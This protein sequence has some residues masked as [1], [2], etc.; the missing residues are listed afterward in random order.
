M[1]RTRSA[2]DAF[3]AGQRDQQAFA[4]VAVDL[5]QAGI[6]QHLVQLGAALDRGDL[7]EQLLR[8]VRRLDAA[9]HQRRAFL[10]QRRAPWWRAITTASSSG[11]ETSAK[12]VSIRL[13]RDLGRG[14]RMA[15]AF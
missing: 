14:K 15:A 11:T 13:L 1:L 5:Q 4:A 12:P 9:A 3:D 6:V 7:L 10:G 8:V 2:A